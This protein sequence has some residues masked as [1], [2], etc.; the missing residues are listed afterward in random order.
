MPA[1]KLSLRSIRRWTLFLAAF[2][3][4]VSCTVPFR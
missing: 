1:Q 2:A 3:L 4:L